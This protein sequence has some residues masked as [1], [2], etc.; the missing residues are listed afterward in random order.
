MSS[1]K[2]KLRNGFTL[3][4]L[5]VFAICGTLNAQSV[6]QQA[7][8]YQNL[9]ALVD[10]FYVDTVNVEKLTE[11]AIVKVLAELDPH[12]IYI[13]KDEIKEMNEALQGSFSGIGIQFNLLRDTLMVVATIPGGP[14]EKVG[15][16]AGDRIIE[17]DNENV[18]AIGMKNTDVHKRLR[19]DK[20]TIVNLKVKRKKE[21][22]LL[23][24]V[25]TRDKIPIHSLDAAYMINKQI[26]YMKLNRFALTTSDEFLEA[27]TKLKAQKMKDLILDLRGNGGGFMT[28][29]IEM[30]DQFMD[31]EKL[32]V[33][34]KGLST[35]RR[36]NISTEK[37]IFKEGR[38]VILLD[39]GSAS[40]SEIVSGAVQDWD[41]G[42]I[43]GRR[44]FGKG[45]VQRQFP[46]SD[47][48]MIRLT[49]AH[50]YTPTGRCIQKPYEN[51]LEDYHLDILK[52]YKSGE[53]INADSIHFPDSLK[54]NT[55]VKKRTVYGGGGIM[56]DIFIP[57][58]T[59]ANY[60][61]F[62]LL[63]RKNVIYPYVVNYMDKNLESLRKKY[64]KFEPFAK[65]FEVSDEMMAEIVALGEKEGIEKTEEDYNAVV[66]DIKLHVKALLARDL[67]ESAEYYKIVNSKNEF[68][69][70]AIEVLKN[71]K[72]Y[73]TELIS[74]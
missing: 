5:S 29:A 71:P 56:P 7:I 17:I 8:K 58:D 18:A 12:S 53:M 33:Y 67:W 20:G 22:E 34:T 37:G 35:P 70:K 23:E 55:L 63:V 50:Y 69:L 74:E 72:L 4:F 62:N 64:P 1:L 40:A 39:E 43:I 10:A 46:L 15:L 48:S 54:Y 60:K 73:D 68:V 36:E 42:V 52:R 49:T 41:R 65:N 61:Y 32:I 30:V 11:D 19:G 28:A 6:K 66:D 24:F 59:T 14:S 47:G 9:L 51:G 38:V 57:I 3:L 27:L 25:I 44:T 45:L 21:K 31:A 16:R 26:G 2:K 13:S